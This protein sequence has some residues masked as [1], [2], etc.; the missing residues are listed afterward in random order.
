[1]SNKPK[2]YAGIGSRDTPSNIT[3]AMI[4]C[5]GYLYTENWVLRSGSAYGADAA[6]EYGHDLF[7]SKSNPPQNRKEIYL[8]WSR[9]NNSI[10]FL[11]P[12]NHPWTDDEISFAADHHPAWWNC[13]SRARNLHIRNGRILRGLPGNENVKFIVCWTEAAM[14]KGGA[15][16]ALR[17]AQ[18]LNIPVFNFGTAS[19]RNEIDEILSEIDEFQKGF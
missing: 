13:S 8:P 6:F 17:M 18:T 2:F 16:Q 11:T 7:A 14:I 10:S 3:D 19:N 15:G 5:G 1:M 4:R 9:Y 12:Y